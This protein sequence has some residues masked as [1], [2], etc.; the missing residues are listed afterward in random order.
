MQTPSF[1]RCS[2]FAAGLALLAGCS[3]LSDSAPSGD[4]SPRARDS[5]DFALTL[6]GGDDA[7]IA[8]G[9]HAYNCEVGDALECE[10][11]AAGYA[12]G[13]GNERDPDRARE[14]TQRACEQGAFWRCAEL[15]AAYANGDGVDRDPERAAFY[16]DAGCRDSAFEVCPTDDDRDC[17]RY[18]AQA[19]LLSARR[20]A[21]GLGTEVN[22][23]RAAYQ[24]QRAC[25][26]GQLMGCY[27]LA[28]T[29]HSGG[30]GEPNLEHALALYEHSC[31]GGHAGACYEAGQMVAHGKGAD[32]DLAR[33]GRHFERACGGD[34]AAGCNNLAWLQCHDQGRCDDSVLATA[35]KAVQLTSAADQG[36]FLD[37]LAFVLCSRGQVSAANAAYEQSC[38]ADPQTACTRVCR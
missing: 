20:Q 31:S 5:H 2:Y 14:F 13:V 7:E 30:F 21:Q 35:R 15:A 34:V 25:G 8:L 29:L 23:E 24:L 27:L 32:R 18:D 17:V 22:M 9:W 11:A 36:Q 19:C 12:E 37:T 3:S 10:R 38:R 16:Y 1:Y 26:G 6:P 4:R 28:D 33:A